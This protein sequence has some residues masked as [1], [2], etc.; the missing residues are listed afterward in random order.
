MFKMGKEKLIKDNYLYKRNVVVLFGFTEEKELR[1]LLKGFL[2]RKLTF[3]ML[4]S[5]KKY[6]KC[7]YLRV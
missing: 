2:H 4:L 7:I 5:I 3:D 6:E 1:V